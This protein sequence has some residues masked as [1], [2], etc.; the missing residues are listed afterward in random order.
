M[1]IKNIFRNMR[2]QR[3]V[4][5]SDMDSYHTPEKQERRSVALLLG[6][7]SLVGTL[8]VALLIFVLARAVYLNF[9]NNKSQ[10]QTQTNGDKSKESSNAKNQK[11]VDQKGKSNGSDSASSSALGQNGN[12]AQAGAP[13][14]P[15]Q[16]PRL[17][18]DDVQS[19][20]LPHTGDD[21]L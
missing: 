1:V 13:S 20:E 15:Q 6:I 12:Q 7:A 11:G 5:P 17:G 19:S 10:V 18:D 16:T 3:E 14:I 9:S 21:G 8:L 2:R 4:L